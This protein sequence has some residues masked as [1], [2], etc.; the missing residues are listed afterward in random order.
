[1]KYIDQINM[2][3]IS[4]NAI[5]EELINSFD[6]KMTLELTTRLKEDNYRTPFNGFKALHLLRDLAISRTE[7]TFDY[8][9][10][11][12]QETSDEN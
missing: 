4:E 5:N 10:L 7:S 2:E 6:E 12:D 11:L 9:Q 1:M 8:I 3:F